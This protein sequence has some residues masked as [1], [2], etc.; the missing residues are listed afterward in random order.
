MGA[1]LLRIKVAE[2]VLRNTGCRK[3]DAEMD[4]NPNTEK[5]ELAALLALHPRMA[6]LPHEVEYL[7]VYLHVFLPDVGE[8]DEEQAHGGAPAVANGEDAGA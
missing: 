6:F 4:T 7:H 3:M 5:G 8:E 2:V 1:A